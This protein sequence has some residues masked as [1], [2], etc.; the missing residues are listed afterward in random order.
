MKWGLGRSASRAAE[1][2][3]SCLGL[4]LAAVCAMAL[5]ACTPDGR[6]SLAAGQPRGATVAFESIDGP[7]P[8]QF[9]RLVQNLNDEAQ[10]RGLAVI[11][12]ETPSAYRVRGYLAATVVKGETTISWVWDVFDGD[13]HRALRISGEEAAKNTDKGRHRDVWNAADDAMLQRIARSSVAQLA[14]F[15]TSS[16][17]A[18][19]TPGVAQVAAMGASDSS[20]EAAGI[21]RIFRASADP[22]A[23][24]AAEAPVAGDSAI[25]VPLPRRKPASDDAVSA[26]ETVTLSAA[27]H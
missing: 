15:L 20:P 8:G 24:E 10:A 14:A 9:H 4:L 7:P 2:P 17:V 21:F 22:V 3:F 13:E 16:E 11:S 25:R 6:Q 23:A 12:R 26:L 5:A 1:F 27:S 18:P 19:G